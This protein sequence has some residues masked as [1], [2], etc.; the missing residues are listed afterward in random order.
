MNLPPTDYDIVDSVFSRVYDI[1]VG[2]IT[3]QFTTGST[4]IVPYLDDC[5][6]ETV[7]DDIHVCVLYLEELR[8]TDFL[9]AAVFP[10]LRPDGDAN[11]GLPYVVGFGLNPELSPANEGEDPSLFENVAVSVLRE[12]LGT[13]HIAS[14]SNQDH[15]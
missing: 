6:H 5:E 4:P 3:D 13:G 9:S 15:S 11:A 14:V 12:E 2:D 8:G 1:V 10:S 7:I